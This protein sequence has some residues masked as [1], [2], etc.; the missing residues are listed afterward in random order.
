MTA[1]ERLKKEAMEKIEKL[2]SDTSV[3]QAT[4]KGSLEEIRDEIDMKIES[5]RE[6]MKR[7]D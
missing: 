5:I 2:F 7:R 6:D 1:H 3:S 4:T